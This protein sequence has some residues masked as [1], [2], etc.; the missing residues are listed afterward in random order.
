M[1][2]ERDAVVVDRET[3]IWI[4]LIR[5]W[6]PEHDPRY[7]PE[8]ERATALLMLRLERFALARRSV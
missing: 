7:N 1:A 8:L 5:E 6:T 4:R 2:D 3:G